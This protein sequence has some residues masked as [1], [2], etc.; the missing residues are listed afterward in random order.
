[1]RAYAAAGLDNNNIGAQRTIRGSFNDLAVLYYRSADYQSLKPASQKKRRRIIE[2]FR[3]QHGD[4]PIARL[5]RAN[6]QDIKNDGSAKPEA[7]NHVLKMLRVLLNYA[8]F[9]D[10][11]PS[12]RPPP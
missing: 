11:I 4:K 5:T 7:T 8:V 6:V 12:I 2:H 3:A 9:L 10:M 1:M